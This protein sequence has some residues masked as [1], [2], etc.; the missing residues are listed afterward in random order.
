MNLFRKATGLLLV[1]CMILSVLAVGIVPG[2]ATVETYAQETVQ[3]SN[4]LHCFDWSYNNI[5]AALP[6]IAAAGYTAVQTSPVQPPKDYNPS[7][8]N[9]NDWW[10]FY[11]PLDLAISDGNTWLGTKEQLTSL[12]TEAETY[13]IKVIVD[14]VANHLANDGTSSGL[15]SHLNSGVASDM[16]NSDYFLDTS[17]W[18]NDDSRYN[19]TQHHQGMP[20]L[21]TQNTYV[22]TK[23]LNLLK[24]CINCGVD[25][26]RFDAAKHIELPGESDSQHGTFGGNFWPTVINGSTEYA[27]SK[28]KPVPFYYGEILGGAGTDISN[29]TQY[30]AI[31]DN[32]TGNS[33]RSSADW[34]SASG[35]ANASY[36]KGAGASKS[37]LW[38]ESHDTY[39]HN[40]STGVSSEVLNRT[41][42]IVGARAESTGLFFARPASTLGSASTDTNWKSTAVTEVNKFK[43]H[44]VGTSEYLSSSGSTAYIVRGSKGVVISKLDGGGSVELSVQMNSGTYTDQVSGNT[45]TVSNGTISGTVG[46]TGVAVVYDPTDDALNY[47]TADTLYFKPSSGEWSQG[48]ERYAMYVFNTATDT[49]A[50]V[51]MSSAGDGYYSAAVPSGNWTNVIFCRMNGSNDTNNW[52]N[53]WN[54]TDNLFPADGTDCYLL[55]SGTWTVY[56]APCAHTYGQPAWS[57]ANDYSSATA[58]F[59]CSQCG[60]VQTETDS[61]PSLNAEETAYTATVTFNG[62]V[63]TNKLNIGGSG[64][65]DSTYT[66]YAID[67]AN[68]NTDPM[69]IYW[70]GSNGENPEWASPVA[71]TSFS[72]TKVYTFDIPTDVVGIIF[73]DST[74]AKQTDNI[75]SGFADGAVWSITGYTNNYSVSKMPDYYLVGSMNSWTENDDYKF[76]ISANS[77]GKVEYKLSGVDLPANAEIKVKGNDNSWYPGGDNKTVDTAD[78]YDV[79]FRPNGDGN[80]DWFNGNENTRYFYLAEAPEPPAPC[81]ITWVDG[82]GNELYTE[83]V[84]AGTIP[85]YDGETPTKASTAQYSYTFSGWSDGTNTYG[86]SDPLPAVTADTT[87]TAQFTEV[88]RTYTV[89]W[90]NYDGTTLETD[91]NVAY[92]THPSYDSSTPIKPD[93][94]NGSYRFLGWTPL[95]TNDTV[96]TGD[97]TFTAKFGSGDTYTITW[98]DG[99]GNTLAEDTV[100]PGERPVY[101]GATPTKQADAQYTYTYNGTWS[102]ELVFAYDD[103]TYT[104]QFDSTVN[105]YTITWV[106]G[107]GDTLD[108]D[109]VAYGETPEYSGATPTKA[110]TLTKSYT[111]SGWSPAVVSVTGNATYTAQ[112]TESDVDTL[113]ISAINFIGW[114]NVY[115]YYWLGGSNNTWP[116]TEMTADANGLVYTASIPVSAEGIIFTDGAQSNT[117]QTNDITTGIEDGARWAI[118][119]DDNSVACNSVPTYYLVGTMTETAWSTDDAPTFAPIRN[120]NGLEEYKVTA[121]LSANDAFKAYGS[122]D[123]WYPSGENTNYVVTSA[124][125]YNIYFRPNGDGHPDWHESVLY[126]ANVTTYTITWNI[127]GV[128]TTEDYEY[129]ATPTHADP[130]KEADAQYT[131]TF[132]G[133]SPAITSVTGNATY[134]ALFDST[135]NEYTITW[136]NDDD[137][138]IDTT[139]VAYGTVPTHADPTK[140]ATAQY[141]YTFNGWDTEPAAVTGA[142]TYKATYTSTVNEYT[143]TWLNDDDSVIDTTTVAYG[144]VPTHAD[145]TKAATAQ[146]T[147]TFNGWDTEPVAV[148]GAATYKATYTSTV[149]EYTIT[150]LD[151]NND[152]LKT[153]QV[154]YGETPAYTGATPTKTATAEY[155]Y[156][157]NNTWSPAIVPVTGI[158][159]YT[160][161]FDETRA[162]YFP[163]HSLTLHGDIGVN[164]YL[165]LTDAEL[166]S[167]V[168]VDFK[169]NN[170][171]LSTYTVNAGSDRKEID[172]MTLYKSTC[173]VCAP[174][175]T[176]TITAEVKVNG[177]T[178]ATEDYTVKTYADRLLA[179]DAQ[180]EKLKTLVTAMLNYGGATQVQF[181]SEHPNNDTSSQTDNMANAGL[182]APAA[183]TTAEI[184]AIEM[185]APDKD[186]IN[187]QLSG[188]GLSYYGYT[189]LLHSKTILRFYFLKE[190]PDD[191]VSKWNV[192]LNGNTLQQAEGFEGADY[193]AYVEAAGIPAYELDTAYDLCYNETSLGEYSALTY[194]KDVLTDNDADETLVNTVTAMYRYHKAALDWYNSQNT[195]QGGGN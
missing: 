154:A 89:T 32:E 61:S 161:Q 42:A 40:E 93:D 9:S 147:Y 124:G 133:W 44:F 33:A 39:E 159:T 140:A 188:S 59:T 98:L 20:E 90:K 173:W 2:A 65:D 87:F 167:G 70:W 11:Q 138:V 25:G 53:K 149:N 182:D 177:V 54:Q 180:P 145:P 142:A 134:T 92:G 16:K 80:S 27:E 68:W 26:F 47:I 15:Y 63:Y 83:T 102:P 95:I 48:N 21:K 23:V 122:N 125:T 155:T 96:I 175:M 139:T 84:T 55:A 121:T 28:G 163:R 156:T 152:T 104:A 112:F 71:M 109:T 18:I 101:S 24:D 8:T 118:W 135:V 190:N 137:S 176:D 86:V 62:T 106:D 49:N 189:M 119:N 41:W 170:E 38:A 56:G 85:E 162:T 143:I 172:G 185:P 46:S 146:Y 164:F 110:S 73:R 82:D 184:N 186:A 193:F 74:G 6:D 81:N 3:G 64:D 76:A 94:A 128:T 99:D 141:T 169:L 72:G 7:W 37:V 174:E 5:K 192:T 105:E 165:N 78:T 116:G 194:V 179:D 148:T 103:A 35:L 17:E 1:L 191:N 29:Y 19:I 75:E 183:L 153:E 132:T 108:T 181:A 31:T 51:S 77:D 114:D 123:T 58:T 117:K 12:C 67:N 97:T 168:T 157:F 126:A 131:Y 4:I 166:T 129:G 150:W 50:W 107:N 113:D 13:G 91:N 136:L 144:T 88:T 171:A 43:N 34:Q 120:D 22:Q 60:D 187:A 178:V 14:V 52:D 100:A 115:V 36:Q 160:A 111:F 69:K 79:Y 151:G 158:A 127:D 30:M 195:N 10:K 57:W 66:I 45:F 130:T